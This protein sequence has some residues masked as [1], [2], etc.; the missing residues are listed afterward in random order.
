MTNGW[1]TNEKKREFSESLRRCF[2]RWHHTRIGRY[3]VVHRRRNN[4]RATYKIASTNNNMDPEVDATN[5]RRG[6]E[7]TSPFEGA[8]ATMQFW[9]SILV[10]LTRQ[11]Q[12]TNAL[13]KTKHESLLSDKATNR[14]GRCLP[15]SVS[16]S[17]P[18]QG[19]LPLNHDRSFRK[20]H[21]LHDC[22]L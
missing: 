21:V 13:R 15:I 18:N 22:A 20:S 10:C 2:Q 11:T 12:R 5:L 8:I 7:W 4:E 17:I 1:R 16:C 6:L 9:E 14:V 3:K 19:S